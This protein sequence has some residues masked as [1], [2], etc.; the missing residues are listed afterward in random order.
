MFYGR[1]VGHS[2]EQASVARVTKLLLRPIN[3][4][5]MHIEIG[6]SRADRDYVGSGK[7]QSFGS[8][9]RKIRWRSFRD[10]DLS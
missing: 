8:P 9:L 1:A 2:P 6:Y 7:V 3:I 5:V 10:V 4:S